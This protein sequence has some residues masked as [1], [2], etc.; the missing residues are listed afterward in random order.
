MRHCRHVRKWERPFL[1][2][3]E[4][5]MVFQ[6]FYVD[7]KQKMINIERLITKD[8]VFPHKIDPL[9]PL[10]GKMRNEKCWKIIRAFPSLPCGRPSL[11]AP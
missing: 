10:T 1:G 9:L 11:K 7:L 3:Y 6:M 8:V 4:V 5:Q 2:T